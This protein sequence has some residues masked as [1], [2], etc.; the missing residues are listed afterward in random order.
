[1]FR[2]RPTAVL[3]GIVAVLVAL[4]VIVVVA[5]SG[6]DGPSLKLEHGAE[7]FPLRGDRA[8]D[9]D[10]L[11]TAA[12]EWIADARDDDRDIPLPGLD[13]DEVEISALWA[14]R[15]GEYDVVILRAGGV[16]AMVTHRRQDN[17][18]WLVDTTDVRKD[19]GSPLPI[20]FDDGVLVPEKL[21]ARPTYRSAI[22]AP[23][24]KVREHDGLWTG[25]GSPFLS[26]GV[27]VL[28]RG[29]G[30][31]RGDETDAPLVVV[32][33]KDAATV[34]HVDAETAAGLARDYGLGTVQRFVAATPP[35]GR[36]GVGGSDAG[37]MR[38]VGEPE[39]PE[40][41]PI[42]VLSTA[43]G[44]LSSRRPTVVTAAGGGS[45]VDESPKVA[46]IA[47]AS[48]D[49]SRENGA[50]RPVL[51]T[52]FVVRLRAP[53]GGSTADE[54]Q[55]SAPYLVAAGTHD[56]RRIEIVEGRR[57]IE[58][59]GPV[60]IVP[61]GKAVGTEDDEQ[62]TEVGVLGWTGGDVLVVPHGRPAALTTF[63]R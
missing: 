2:R 52:G 37:T 46:T 45:D 38:I 28:P 29:T 40:L 47:L 10:L 58:R 11:R 12:E 61:A 9:G 3:T 57:R 23:G 59:P 24:P 1:M 63:G 7:G 49:Q 21:P 25:D 42:L 41:G 53:D 55:R 22:D 4:A 30:G 36:G 15:R 16:A 48:Q 20:A 54:P 13:D 50:G 31:G 33:G 8:Q 14:G 17:Q 51:A 35:G 26:D 39:H 34:R 32:T 43:P 6:D 44:V 56:V 5:G 27:L 60:A 62:P 18:P 19:L